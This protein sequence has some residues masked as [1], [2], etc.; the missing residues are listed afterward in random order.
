MRRLLLLLLACLLSGLLIVPTV[1]AQDPPTQTPAAGALDPT[2]AQAL[3]R[4]AVVL[5][6]KRLARDRATA[7]GTADPTLD[8]EIRQL[9][10]QFAALAARFD[11]QGFEAPQQ[12]KFDLQQELEQLIRPLLRMLKDA[13]AEPRQVADLKARLE[14]VQQR[15]AQAARAARG[16]ERTRDALPPESPARA[17]AEREL[18][19]RWAPIIGSLRDEMLVLQANLGQLQEGKRSLV[20]TATGSVKNFLNS[21]GTSLVLSVLVFL[22][23]FFGLR[24]VVDLLLRRRRAARGFSLRLLEVVL[25][26]LVV[27]AAVAA[28]LVVPYARDDF[29]LLAIGIV[30][31]LGAGWVLV[32]MAPQFVEQVRLLLNI[33]GVRE[34]ERILVDGLPFQVT[35][36]RFYT[37]LDNPDLQGGALRVPVQFLIGRRSRQSA[38]DEPWFPTRVGDIVLLQD[39][40]FG[41]VRVQTPETV[42]V[43]HLGAPRSLPTA[44]FLQQAP[45]NLSR[46]FVLDVTLPLGREPMRELQ[47]DALAGLEHELLQAA[48]ARRSPDAVRSL[49]VQFQQVTPNGCELLLLAT[50]GGELAADYYALRRGLQQAF[51]QAC[52]RRGWALPAPAVTA[53]LPGGDGTQS[54]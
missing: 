34:G 42:V 4:L 7:A 35:A 46:G 2:T 1:R 21:S 26:L 27:L 18:R 28:T 47:P 49:R 19:Q 8:T 15:H 13:T 36:L 14:Q 3:D 44:A 48:V 12:G 41:P 25:R 40:T 9:S 5:A 50:C 37:R 53:L 51:V 6:E 11:V 20:E 45:R 38:P 29:L 22:S 31:L 32:R 23:V 16:V 54:A 10:W 33:G 43:E 17:E 39:G 30:F 24:F 52:A